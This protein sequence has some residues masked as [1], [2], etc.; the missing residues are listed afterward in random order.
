MRALPRSIVVL[1]PLLLLLPVAKA[2]GDAAVLARI[3]VEGK[4]NSHVWETLTYLSEE[5]GPRLTGSTRLMRANAW[6]RDEFRRLGLKNA[7]L[8]KWG[9]IPVRFDR[10]PSFARMV[11]PSEREFEFS[12][13][14]WSQGTD[15]P[16][17]ARVVLCP[18]TPEEL[19]AATADLEGTW[20]LC[21][22]RPRR[23]RRGGGEQS[24]DER[25]AREAR[26]AVDEALAQIDVA[27]RLSSSSNELV[28]TGSAR[29][30]RELTMDELPRGIDVTIRLSDYEALA[31][32][33]ESGAEVVAEVD[34]AHHFV[35][36]PFGV[37][38][39]V[40]EIPGTELPEEVV[41]FSGHLDSWDGPGSSG[42]QDNG[43]GC[44]VML[45]AARI[46][47]AAGVRPRRTIRFCLWT[48]EEQGLFGSRGYVE[49]LSEE[50]R[51]RISACFVDDGGTNY[52]GGL[53]CIESQK[54]M[55][56]RAIAPVAQAF[57]GLEMENAVRDR[58]PRGGGS[59]H[60]PFNQVGIP[61]FF[62]MEKGSGGREDKDYNFIHH[63][64]NDTMRYAV[65]EYLVQSATCSAVVA[66]QLAEAET[67]LPRELPEELAQADP[68]QDPTFEPV[69]GA[70]NGDWRVSFVSADAPDFSFSLALE[71]AADGRL[72]GSMT[73]MSGPQPL[74]DGKWERETGGA[75]FSALTDF[76][77]VDFKARVEEGL[78]RGSLTAMGGELEFR[79]ER[80]A[81]AEIPISGLWKGLIL[82]MDA[83]FTL[84]LAVDE[85]GKV[86]GRF[87]S[88]QSDSELYDGKWDAAAK[89]VRF[90][91][92]YP[93]AGRL[94][95]AAQL[96]GQKLVGTIGT[97][98]FEAER[99]GRD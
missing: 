75:T 30:W 24:D 16:L 55:L 22:P 10:G 87:K 13:S 26:A 54:E 98:G 14:A 62:W 78:L 91:Y 77:K 29:G 42:A 63:T 68:A 49:S 56:D 44:A 4:E 34:L 6:T 80:E 81:A 70:F 51:A 61:G 64:Q 97:A 72:R 11:A 31:A 18:E 33:L 50:E 74:N 69:A 39:T 1:S 52:Q 58:M 48:G 93:N 46:L 96:E 85:G 21:K 79:G 40:A 88:S 53:T 73:G 41:I 95:V 43:T 89:T 67:L 76:G 71:M 36:G 9:E 27:G 19:E 15:G 2:Q 83:E 25:A 59:D 84:D 3:L 32:E 47:M 92:E 20:V 94:P 28:H 5:I 35:E 12:A 37:Y 57:P 82:S 8:Q 7:H 23:G 66:Y 45:E 65:P 60:A 38:N 17:R 86:T 90:E 99:Q